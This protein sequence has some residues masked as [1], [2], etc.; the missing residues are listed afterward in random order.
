MLE[1]GRHDTLQVVHRQ[2]YTHKKR[3]T[4]NKTNTVTY[5]SAKAGTTRKDMSH[6]DMYRIH[7]SKFSESQH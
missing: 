7:G 3:A 2:D 4:S 5:H 6:S 1:E